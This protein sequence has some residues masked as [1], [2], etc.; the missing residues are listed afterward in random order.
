MLCKQAECIM[1][2]IISMRQFILVL[3]VYGRNQDWTDAR[4]LTTFTS[5]RVYPG[6][7]DDW[8][9]SIQFKNNSSAFSIQPERSDFPLNKKRGSLYASQK[10]N[11]PPQ[12]VSNFI[13]FLDIFLV[14][15]S[16]VVQALLCFSSGQWH[17]LR[18]GT[19]ALHSGI[20]PTISLW[21]GQGYSRRSA[22]W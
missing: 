20:I 3:Y 17:V 18:N 14:E 2:C 15:N 5:S 1:A 11:L 4:I 7:M 8:M 12:L 13:E 16:H 21:S 22:S 9:V 10:Q 6:W 19:P